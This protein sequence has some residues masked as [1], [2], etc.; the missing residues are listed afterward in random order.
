MCVCV[1]VCTHTHSPWISE[2]ETDT[3]MELMCNWDNWTMMYLK[4]FTRFLPMDTEENSLLNH[5]TSKQDTISGAGGT[6]Q[7]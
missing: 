6:A 1:F 4:R 2:Q 5:T 3:L 7:W